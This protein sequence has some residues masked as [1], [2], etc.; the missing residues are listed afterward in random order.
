MLSTSASCPLAKR[1]IFFRKEIGWSYTI[2]GN[3]PVAQLINLSPVP[4]ELLYY[5]RCLQNTALA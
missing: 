2:I 3:V 5:V 1:Y 4:F